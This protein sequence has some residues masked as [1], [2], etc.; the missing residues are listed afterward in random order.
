MWNYIKELSPILWTGVA[1]SAG[2]VFHDTGILGLLV[3]PMAIG[4][5]AAI[6][7]EWHDEVV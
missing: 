7:L 3:V 2:R 5:F 1:Y 6:C 4:I